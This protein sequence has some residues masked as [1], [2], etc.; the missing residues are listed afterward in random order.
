[1]DNRQKRPIMYRNMLKILECSPR[2][3]VLPISGLS[4][5]LDQQGSVRVTMP[6]GDE[7]IMRWL[8]V[9]FSVGEAEALE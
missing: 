3:V 6:L 5:P 9:G 7:E 8:A 4:I 2:Q 1:M